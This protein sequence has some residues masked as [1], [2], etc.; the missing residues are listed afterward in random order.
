MI[1][2]KA[3]LELMQFAFQDAVEESETQVVTIISPAGLGKSRLLNEFIKWS[4]L[5]PVTFRIFRGRATS[6]MT[7]RPYALLRDVLSFRFEILDNDAPEIVSRK[8]EKGVAELVGQADLEMAHTVGQLAGFDFSESPFV[9]GILGDPE[10]LTNR[11]KQLFKRLIVQV[12]TEMP[13]VFQLEDI[14]LA[15]DA[16]LDLFIELAGENQELPLLMISL[17]RP[18]LLERRPDWGAGLSYHTLIQVNPLTRRESRNLVSEILQKAPKVPK[19]LRDEIVGHAEGNPYFMEEVIKMLIE[20]RVIQKDGELWHIEAS[21]LENLRV[22][23]SLTGLIQ[24]RIDSLLYP[25]K[26]LLQRASVVG[27]IFHDGAMVSLDKADSTQIDD[28]QPVLESLIER[29]FIY[30]R[31]TSSFEGETEY[32]FAQQMVRDV[33]YDSLLRRQRATYHSTTA[34]W[35]EE[36]AGERLDEYLPMIAEHYEE[37]G[38]Y[39][40]AAEY[41][42]RSAEKANIVSA[43]EDERSFLTHAMAI[44]P[45]EAREL[46]IDILNLFGKLLY[47]LDENSKAEELLTDGLNLARRIGDKGR[48]AKALAQLSRVLVVVKG[49]LEESKNYIDEALGLGVEDSDLRIDILLSL[50]NINW[51]QGDMDKSRIHSMEALD[52]ARGTDDQLGVLQALNV[53]GIVASHQKKPDEA[54]ARFAELNELAVKIGNRESAGR[55]FNNLGELYRVEGDLESATSAYNQSLSIWEEIGAILGTRI[56]HINLGLIALAKKDPDQARYHLIRTLQPV[57]DIE[58]VAASLYDILIFAGIMALEGDTETAMAWLGMIR[59]HPGADA[60]IM[61]DL[62]T[63]LDILREHLSEDKLAAG[64]EKG[65]ELEYEQVRKVLYENFE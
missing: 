40:R 11:A 61:V 51:R 60:N 43:F 53:L 29:E 42:Y 54:R 6:N 39:D 28:I 5:N 26:L 47:F 55:G 10:Q 22:P 23:P 62:D 57:E 30:R 2:R 9:Q 18:E 7:H 31:E 37:G 49:N 44:V 65:R 52:I 35:L 34:S 33:I 13:V 15:D 20:D 36:V 24:A 48:Q 59:Q 19:R 41:L 32:I 46:R 21:R 63:L 17:A 1:G 45:E 4:E 58:A 16:S 8:M 25:E 27:R 14:H 12:S 38:Q 50:S 3:E 64:M 56:A